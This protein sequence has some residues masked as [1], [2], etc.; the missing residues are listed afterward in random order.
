MAPG[1]AA[2]AIVG[3]DLGTTN[4]ALAW[5]DL[6]DNDLDAVPSVRRF[7]IPQTLA[8][9]EVGELDTLPSCLYLASPEERERGAFDL[10]WASNPSRVAG[11]W[12]RDHGALRPG[13][14]VLSAKSWLCHPDVDRR[15]RILPWDADPTERV[16]S[17]VEASSA[18]LA[19]LRDAWNHVVARGRPEYR[20]ERQDLVLTVPASFDEEARELTVEAARATGFERLLLQEEPSAA[21]YAWL[22][23]HRG[24]ARSHLRP[25]D[26]VLVCDVGG[27]TTDFTL[28]AVRDAGDELAF[29]RLAVGDHLLLGGDN[30]DLA[31]ARLVET[32]LGQET[33][34]LRQRQ[35][36]RRQCSAAKERLLA[37]PGPDEVMVTVLG[38]GRAVVGGARSV[39]IARDEV[40]RLLLD[41][42]LPTVGAD[43]R[44]QRHAR[45]GLRELGLP[46]EEDPGITRHLAQFLAEAREAGAPARPD[47]VLFNGGFF[48][49]A[50]ARERVVEVLGRW[51]DSG[52]AHWRPRI[53]AN[54]SPATAVAEGAASYGLARRGYGPRIGGGSPRAYYV[55]LGGHLSPDARTLSAVCVLPRGTQEGVEAH[56]GQQFEVVANEQRAFSLWSSRTRQDPLGEVVV[57]ERDAVHAHTPLAAELRYGKRSRAVSLRVSL[58]VHYTELGTIE[59]WLSSRGTDHRWRL[60]FDVRGRDRAASD[61]QTADAQ[62]AVSPDALRAAMELA[63]HV[64][65]PRASGTGPTSPDQ[66]PS[67]LEAALGLGR[68]AWPVHAIRPLADWLLERAEG[69]T[70]SPR[71][72]ARWLNLLGLCLRPGFGATRDEWRMGQLR[73][74]YLAGLAFPRDVQCQSEWLV[75]W[76]RVAGGLT[77]GQQQEA[78]QRVAPTLLASLTKKGKR[79]PPQVERES[80]RLLASLERLPAATRGA[81]G[82]ELVARLPHHSEAAT[83]WWALGRLG[84]RVPVYG[85][86]NTVVAPSVAERWL[87]RVSDARAVPQSAFPALVDIAAFTQDPARDVDAATR[88]RLADVL[89][90]AGATEDVVVPLVEARRAT[91]ADLHRQFGETLP[92]GL[93]LAREG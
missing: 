43:A 28:V 11:V 41:G 46:F 51:F 19:H 21:L 82:D 93:A 22:A 54:D 77:A 49:P 52:D 55:G 3:I 24:A 48:T 44:P 35:A 72:E 10:P 75:L 92:E 38:A 7:A 42:F 66:L 39:P 30:L 81:L 18:L 64:F 87:A 17:P 4:S 80:W 58:D 13:Q 84:A 56:V 86:L 40:E 90:E 27:G 61:A 14:L 25:G 71:H 76:Q 68:L 47:V 67:A 69:R 78:Y 83:L 1:D 36:L 31:L 29:E 9:G 26:C 23:A 32:R 63:D 45:H 88:H 79:L 33:L 37:S 70:G 50:L 62:A 91:R 20:L 15:S 73:R 12:A 6:P 34:T 8:E 60:Q 59:L 57:L 65:G 74:V 53:L 2:R 5:A 85:P 16:C 89:R